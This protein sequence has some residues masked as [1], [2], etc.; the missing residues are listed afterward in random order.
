MGHAGAIISGGDDT[1]D[2]KLKALAACGI[3]TT[4]SPAT[5]G[6]AMMKALGMKA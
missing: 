5:I 4:D 3:T 1:A 6:E 2:A